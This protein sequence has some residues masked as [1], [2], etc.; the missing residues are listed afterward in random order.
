MHSSLYLSTSRYLSTILDQ[1]QVTFYHCCC[2]QID[3][4]VVNKYFSSKREIVPEFFLLFS[5]YDNFQALRCAEIGFHKLQKSVNNVVVF[6][7]FFHIIWGFWCLSQAFGITGT[8]CTQSASF[9]KSTKEK[10]P[11]EL[12]KTKNGPLL[13]VVFSV[14]GSKTNNRFMVILFFWL[15]VNYGLSNYTRTCMDPFFH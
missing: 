2:G 10:W 14:S 7:L 5:S 8:S 6:V 4:N 11:K 1:M 13:V 12:P 15:H 3:R 9:P